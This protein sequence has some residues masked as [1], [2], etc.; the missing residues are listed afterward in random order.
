GATTAYATMASPVI[1]PDGCWVAY[2]SNARGIVSGVSN[3][4]LAEIY[5]RDITTGATLWPSTNAI[6]LVRSIMQF[7]GIPAP[8]HPVI[9]DDGRYVTF[10]CG[11]TNCDAAAPSGTTFGTVILQFDAISGTTTIIS[12]NG[13]PP[14]GLRDDVY[15]PEMT[16]DGR[17]VAFTS[18]Q[19]NGL[20][21]FCGLYYWDRQAG[22]NTVV[23]ADLSGNEAT[24]STS[25]APVLSADGRFVTFV[26][27]A[28]N[29]VANTVASG[30]HIYRRD[31]ISGSTQLVDA[32]LAGN[33]STIGLLFAL[34]SMSADGRFV[35]YSAPDGNLVMDDVNKAEDVFVWDGA[36]GTNEVI[37]LRDPA[38]SINGGDLMTC[39]GFSLSDDG[40]RVAFSSRA[41][42]LTVNDTNGVSDVFVWD[43]TFESNVLVSAGMDGLPALGGPSFQPQISGDGRY[44]LFVS[45]ATNLVPNDTKGL[46]N[47]FLRDLQSQTTT[48]LSITT[49]GI[50]LGSY[51]P[52]MATMT[53]D[54]QRVVF[55]GR[56]NISG[57]I[58]QT[59]WRDLPGGT[60]RLVPNG[61]G[62]LRTPTLSTNGRRIAYCSSGS[63]LYVWDAIGQTN[64]YYNSSSVG[65]AAISPG[66]NFVLYG[67]GTKL[68]CYD[69]NAR[70]NV[71]SWL[72]SVPVP[73]SQAWSGD[74]RYV[75]FVSATAL[76]SGDTNALKDVY[77]CDL[78]TGALSLV[79][80]SADGSTSGSASS[81]LPVFSADGRFVVYRSFATNIL[82][83][84]SISPGIFVF[85]RLTGSNQLVVARS[86]VPGPSLTSWPAIS[87]HGDTIAFA[88]TDP[89]LVTARLNRSVNAFACGL[90]VFSTMDGD[91]DGIP[92]W[93]TQQYF[94]HGTG[95]NEDHSLAT[96]DADGDGMSNLQEFLAGTNPTDIASFLYMQITPTPATGTNVLLSWPAKAGRGYRVQFTDDLSSGNWQNIPMP[97]QVVGNQ[98]YLTLTQTN[99]MRC[100]RVRCEP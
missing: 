10:S 30:W 1:T 34:P 72:S 80:S 45:M 13:Y 99:L 8:R 97:V 77:L 4:S 42:N 16:P 76:V 3:A 54:A 39:G 95:G 67:I 15:G 27:N 36:A 49:N 85:D 41:S 78:K 71:N 96:D 17:F 89:G 100:F 37:S 57:S 64:V 63:Q 86:P 81:D 48:L 88:T 53:S 35:S 40:S 52:P 22:S 73:A 28:T 6:N 94:G 60:T 12:T 62:Y 32:D 55:V 9:S 58:Y 21:A 46:F 23:S 74:E 79:S 70:S 44:V 7:T 51:D 66:G 26:S 98:G 93:W 82:P 83:S 59:F 19:T 18:R 11:W 56:T 68:Y 84:A 92:D 31:L 38:V 14:A 43:R 91:S 90:S 69:L 47:V 29:L 2:L 65:S 50:S 75:A 20:S 61:T 24:N 5:L 33:G 87:A 25:L